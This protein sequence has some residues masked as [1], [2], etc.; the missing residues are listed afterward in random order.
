MQNIGSR[1]GETWGTADIRRHIHGGCLP[2]TRQNMPKWLGDMIQKQRIRYR[3]GTAADARRKLHSIQERNLE[4]GLKEQI[5][6]G[7]LAA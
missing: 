7:V 2:L 5:A 3:S 1:A 6:A 4:S